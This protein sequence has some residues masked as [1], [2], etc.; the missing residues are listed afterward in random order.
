MH[1]VW[2][3]RHRALRTPTTMQTV[4]CVDGAGQPYMKVENSNASSKIVL[5]QKHV[6]KDALNCSTFPTSTPLTARWPTLYLKHSLNA[7]TRSLFKFII[8]QGSIN[9]ARVLL[10]SITFRSTILW[11]HGYSLHSLRSLS[12]S[13]PGNLI[14][15]PR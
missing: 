3:A 12:T 6:Q 7:P 4:M 14:S 2:T 5:G 8:Y 10:L 11:L 13:T 9:P 15:C 1:G